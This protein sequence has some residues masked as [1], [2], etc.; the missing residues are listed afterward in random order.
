MVMARRFDRS[1]AERNH[2][3][4]GKRKAQEHH[5]TRQGDEYACKCG[6]R[7]DV[8]DGSDHP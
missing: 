1:L 5:I 4:F 3:A 8:Q 7:W 6:R 2:R